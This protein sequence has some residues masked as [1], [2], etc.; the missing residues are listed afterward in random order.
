MDNVQSNGSQPRVLITG[1][2]GC[3]GAETAKWLVRSSDSHVVIG[4]RDISE[5]RNTAVFGGVDRSRM[6]FEAIDVRDQGCLES[7]LS[8][9]KISH[10]VHMAGLQTP[11]CNANRD[12]G[13]QVNLAGTQNL[14]EAMKA[15]NRS[16]DRFIFASSMAVY[17]PRSMY[18]EG[19]VP[20]DATTCP[21][22]VYG[23]WKIAGEHVARIFCEDTGVPTISVRPA[24]LFGPGRDRGLT[25]SPTTAMKYLAKG[26]PY[27]IPYYNQQDYLYAPDVGAAVGLALLEPFSQY[28]TFTLPSQTATTETLVAAM[29]KA[30]NSLGLADKFAIT[31]G[32]QRVP[33]ACDVDFQPFVNA[34]PTAPL[35]PID[36]AISESIEFFLENGS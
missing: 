36:A 29:R 2:Y 11:D 20:M 28:A 1:G 18:P 35:T 3:I 10:V 21:V 19:R 14:V 7:V 15:A 32:D 30:A 9:H 26:E 22:N 23:A 31:I 5:Q 6:S 34:F 8:R 24:V 4:S 13:L 17:G 33:F 16:F 25:A 12:L 27:E